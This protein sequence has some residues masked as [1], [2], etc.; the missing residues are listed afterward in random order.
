MHELPTIPLRP[1][2]SRIIVLRDQSAQKSPGGLLHIPETA[3]EILYSGIVLRTGPGRDVICTTCRRSQGFRETL[4]K[5]GDRVFW[6]RYAESADANSRGM[7]V[8]GFELLDDQ[9]RERS[10]VFLNGETDLIGREVPSD[11]DMGHDATAANIAGFELFRDAI[12]VRRR[13]PASSSGGIV[14]PD[15]AQTPENEG[16]IIA[17]G[18]GGYDAHG[19][20]LPMTLKVGQHVWWPEYAETVEPCMKKFQK[21]P[22][23]GKPAEQI[24][25]LLEH[26]VEHAT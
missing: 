8:P 18:P 26:M 16:D 12:A 17:V 13:D 15:S 9:G 25:L 6:K 4:V 22:E 10:V 7:K 19:G 1:L 14:I 2:G 11:H 21:K 23:A 5:R 24:V 3:Q 20:F